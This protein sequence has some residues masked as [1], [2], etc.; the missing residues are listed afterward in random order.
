MTDS[1]HK[2]ESELQNTR[3]PESHIDP[4]LD[5][6]TDLLD[7]MGSPQRAYPVVHIAGTNGKTS[8]ARM[9]DELLRELNVRTGRLTSPH[10]QSIT[11]RISLDSEPISEERFVEVYEEIAPYLDLVDARHD[12]K[13]S[14]FEVL[15]AMGFAA[16][17]DTPVDVGIVEVGLGGT[18]DATN[19]ADGTVAVVTPIA[20]DHTDYLG[21]T[22]EEI[23]GEKAG[24]IK[25]ASFAVLGAQSAAAA[26][27][28]LGR[29]AE[30]GATVAR[31]GVEFGVR[32]REMAVGG[33]V[34]SLQGLTGPYDDIFL[35]L[36]G[37]HQAANAVQALATVEAFAGGG[38]EGLD[39]EAV[40]AA[41]ARVTSPGRLE[42]LRR[43]PVVLVDAAH[44]PAGAE[45]LANALEDEFATTRLVA[46][47]AVLADKD[48]AGIL[49]ALE[50]VVEA[51]VVTTNSSPRCL[52]AVDLA[53][54]ASEVF[55]ENRVFQ[56]Q[57]LP[58]AI[59]VGLALA[60]RDAP[61]GGHGV[62]VTGSVI[63]AGDARQA[64]G[65]TS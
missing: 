44:N 61:M 33:Q 39:P 53:R 21:D 56:A 37:E 35:P 6:I 10:L 36:H 63:T 4:T 8:T 59:D 45:A 30:V 23:A 57:P 62:I 20:L 49:E 38:R 18:W 51:V 42:P 26:E 65:A 3:W 41:F 22:I 27:V 54:I 28:L 1:L 15:T 55:G 19:V 12:H 16:F 2:I 29:A 25:P 17:A 7:V 58:E 24:I 9:I 43:G 11:E 64:F 46:V 40:R 47:M 50:P 31:Q 5:R 60:E 13:L 52:P 48:A 32:N 34:V 14:Y